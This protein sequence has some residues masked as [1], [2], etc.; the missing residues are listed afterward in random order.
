M[1]VFYAAVKSLESFLK[2][3]YQDLDGVTRFDDVERIGTIARRL[4]NPSREL[5]LLILFH[6]LPGWLDKVGNLSRTLL[7]CDVTEAELRKTAAS[8]KRLDDPVT[9][10]ER[11]LASAIAIDNAG[12]AG[13]ARELGR[14]RREG[15]TIE[16]VAREDIQAPEWMRGEAR[17]MFEE[18]AARRGEVCRE[19]LK[20]C[21]TQNAE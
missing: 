15:R 9:D 17:K 7:A 3:L 2:P 14:A 8:L 6:A 20:E 19:I 18:R 11:A 16:E 1:T 21:R 10:A 13:L 4:A 12:V 5:E